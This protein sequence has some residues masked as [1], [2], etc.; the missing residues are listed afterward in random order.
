[1]ATKQNINY[2]A[3]HEQTCT[4]GLGFDGM[5]KNAYAKDHVPMR[6]IG[7]DQ[8]DLMMK[9]QNKYDATN[10]VIYLQFFKYFNRHILCKLQNYL[11]EMLNHNII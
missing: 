5:E 6:K 7:N 3:S 4:A 11:L 9:N 8:I 2:A 1:M 10:P